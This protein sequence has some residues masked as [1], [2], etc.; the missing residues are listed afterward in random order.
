[1]IKADAAKALKTY[2]VAL[3]IPA[4]STISHALLPSHSLRQWFASMPWRFW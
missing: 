2:L 1:M 3:F 4:Y